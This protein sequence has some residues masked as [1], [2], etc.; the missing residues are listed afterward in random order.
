[1]SDKPSPKPTAPK[2]AGKTAGTASG[3]K[4][5][6]KNRSSEPD[7]T[8][9][10]LAPPKSSD[11]IG[12]LAHYRVLRV[13]GKGGMG[14]VF[15]AED[16]RLYRIVALKVM[17]PSIAKKEVA[18]DR[19][20]REAR[21]TAKIDHDHIITIYEVN[22]NSEVPYAAMQYLKGMTL[23][24]WLKAGKTLNVPQIM[25]IGKEIAKGLAAAHA[26]GLI[27]RDIKPSNIWL[28]AANK[29]RVKI[30][31][32]GLAR[33]TNEETHLTQEGLILGTPAYMSPEQARANAVDERCDLFSL[34]CVL[35]R[36][37]AG[38]LPFMG[39]DP[40]SMLLAIQ[41]DDPPDLQP[42]NADVPPA[43][44]ELIQKLLAKKPADRPESA[45]A[46]V[47][48]IQ[49]IERDWIANG[50][51]AAIRSAAKSNA[52]LGAE[53]VELVDPALEESAITELELIETEPASEP[54]GPA[55]GRA[56]ILAGL[57]GALFALLSIFCCLGIALVTDQ[58]VI[59]IVAADDTAR[60]LVEGPGLTVWDEQNKEH[61]VHLGANKLP[62][63][64]Y[65][66]E[67]TGLPDGL[68]FDPNPFSLSRGETR[69]IKISYVTPRPVQPA[70]VEIKSGDAKLIQKEWATFLRRDVVI[71]NSVDAKLV[72]IPPGEFT[73]GSSKDQLKGM[74]IK[75][76]ILPDGYIARL[77][78]ETPPHRVQITK[79]FYMG[80][81]EVTFDQ[82]KQFVAA[83]D[84]TTEPAASGKGG[85][86][87]D[88][89]KDIG[90]NTKFS[91]LNLGPGY[92]P[93]K[94]SPVSNISWKDAQAFC[95][96]L[97][98]KEKKTYRLPTEAEWEYACRAGSTE[99]WSFGDDFAPAKGYMWYHAFLKTDKNPATPNPVAKKKAN[100]FGLFDMHG[101]V[102]EMCSDLWNPNYYERCVKEN[103]VADPKGPEPGRDMS[104]VVRGGSFIESAPVARSAYRNFLDPTLGHV[105][106]GFR[107]VCEIPL[108]E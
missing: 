90:R 9:A 17:L 88:T 52:A 36:L 49:N 75:K 18:R 43:L 27:H 81:T 51:T 63:E 58:G 26:Q 29:G 3:T 83:K 5:S 61:P 102:A 99:L 32:F 50:K 48:T 91:W 31:D 14:T 105:Q 24:D 20:I 96:W 82:F 28:D 11:E 66:F 78:A 87:L 108:P 94:T 35:Y 80:A 103:L 77:A 84:Y 59:D 46:V 67:Q 41:T 85:T 71:V 23:E 89:G 2:S 101:N 57:G 60:K 64:R 7:E 104:R 62:P 54:Q 53:G 44:A 21:A 30:L 33:P 42:L 39:K 34:G 13:L 106:V 55:R 19:F 40:M 47:T 25:R 98:D 69:T 6:A 16:T 10:F 72:L 95:A 70:L 97:S 65:R 73:M 4:G 38:K 68:H 12:R 15:M 76:E 93:T 22:E 74:K 56:W 100:E 45:K 8:F 86:G 79:P 1:M 37:C 92:T 107:V